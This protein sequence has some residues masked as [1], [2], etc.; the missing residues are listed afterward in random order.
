M[1]VLVT[2]ASGMV[3]TALVPALEEAGHEVVRLVR[4]EAGEGEVR[5]DPVAGELEAGDLAGV[6]GVVHLAGENV[7]G[8]Y[9]TAARKARILESRVRG[10]D[11]LARALASLETRLR[12]FLSAS[13]V[14]FYGSRGDEW[15]EESASPGTGF[16]A[17]VCQQW[18]TAAAPLAEG[19]TRVLHARLGVVVSPR[20]GALAKMLLPFK[21][22]VG[23][24][25]GSGTQ[26]MS[27]VS[28]P[29]VVRALVFLLDSDLTGPVNLVA[30]GPVTN[31]EFTK[32]LGRALG[33][34]TV[35]P[36]PAPVARLVLGEMADEML[37]AS[38][39]ARPA[40]LQDAGFEFSH[41]GLDGCLEDAL[42]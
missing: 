16:L 32:A 24:R 18:E 41:P 19:P 17:E 10:T 27:W 40:V 8:G 36:L 5:W 13:A 12:V 14:G 1:R 30:P 39:R 4:R 38:Q 37:L 21:M 7:G 33:R 3:G 26:W 23:G 6:E 31:Y 11:L 35:F 22:G 20:G 42:A 29:D 25:V 9:W 2:G 34:P 15:L 28:L